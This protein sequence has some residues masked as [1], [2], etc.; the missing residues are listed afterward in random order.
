MNN[1][2]WAFQGCRIHSL[3]IN[4]VELKDCFEAI[5]DLDLLSSGKYYGRSKVKKNL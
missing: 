2:E 1:L 5:C 4:S 3:K